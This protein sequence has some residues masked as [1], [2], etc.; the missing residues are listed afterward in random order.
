LKPNARG[1]PRPKAEATQD[2]SL[3]WLDIQIHNSG[4]INRIYEGI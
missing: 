3:R 4:I 2:P 1:E